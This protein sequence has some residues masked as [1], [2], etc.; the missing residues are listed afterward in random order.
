M[1]WADIG[2]STGLMTRLAQKLGYNVVGYDLNYFSLLLAK[3]LSFGLKNFT[4]VQIDFHKLEQKFDI[5]SATSLLS[6]VEN[7]EES[8]S[9]LIAL[10]KDKSST[11]IIIE[12]TKELTLKNVWSLVNNLQDFWFYKGLLLWTKARENKSI[13][14]NI[15]LKHDNIISTHK[16][17]LHNMI[18]VS[19]IKLK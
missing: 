19:Y 10:L 15:F 3:I 17:F 8:L 2:C 7:K 11:L 13:S 5:L 4:Y 14:K 1:H 9:K 18:R 6:V 16:Y 12:P